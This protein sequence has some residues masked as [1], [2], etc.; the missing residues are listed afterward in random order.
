VVSEEYIVGDTW[1]RWNINKTPYKDESSL[2][3]DGAVVV[4]LHDVKLVWSY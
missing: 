3:A 4:I 1:R 2:S